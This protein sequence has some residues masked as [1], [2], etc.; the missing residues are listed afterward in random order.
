M[1]QA[2]LARKSAAVPVA[3]TQAPKAEPCGLRIG[4]PDDAFEQEADR[5]A[6]EVTAGGSSKMGWSLARVP[7]DARLQ[8]KCACGGAGEE[9]CEECKE[10]KEMTL[11][12][13]STGSGGLP[14]VPPI[15]HEV[16][17]SPGQS[18]DAA[19]KAFFEPRF[20]HDFSQVR[21]HSGG[22]AA[23][24][25]RS[26]G[27]LAYTAGNDIVF[28]TGQYNPFSTI[29]RGLLAHELTHV[30]QQRRAP[31]SGLV[32]QRKEW[33]VCKGVEVPVGR[34]PTVLCFGGLSGPVV[35]EAKR[36]LN[37]LHQQDT[38]WR[39][40][41]ENEKDDDS[42]ISAIQAFQRSR[43]LNRQDGALMQETMDA[44]EGSAPEA[45]T[46][47]AAGAAEFSL[48]QTQKHLD[49]L[50]SDLQYKQAFELLATLSDAQLR[51]VIAGAQ[52][53]DV[54]AGIIMALLAHFEIALTEKIDPGRL[55]VALEGVAWDKN[56]LYVDNFGRFYVDPK[57]FRR[58][59]ERERAGK[60]N[61]RIIFEYSLLTPDRAIARF[62]D[63]IE[64]SDAKSREAPRQGE[65]GLYYPPVLN[66]GN[67]P[68]MWQAKKDVIAKIEEGNF[69]FIMSAWLATDA[70][71]G[72]V[73]FGQ[74]MLAGTIPAA[75]GTA[76]AG[77]RGTS[78]KQEEKLPPGAGEPARPTQ[79]GVKATTPSGA[80]E[81]RQPPG[82]RTEQGTT[83]EPIKAAGAVKTLAYVNNNPKAS[84]GEI[85]VGTLLD[86]KAQAG[87]LK[88]FTRVE[89]AAEIS[90]QPSGDYRFTQPD[91]T[92][93][94]GDLYQ[95][96][97]KNVNNIF[98]AIL[99]KGRQGKIVVVELGE[100]ESGAITAD[101]ATEL[102]DSVVKQPDSGVRRV[103]VVK[104][105]TIVADKP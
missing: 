5:V 49:E 3:T 68:K 103:I 22:S 66:K 4:E 16:L 85:R 75:T 67:T 40:L 31:E 24:S 88:E 86:T 8:R 51:Q 64:D 50:V 34:A 74:S 104:G 76:A 59:E 61:I 62:A 54:G 33:A 44:L 26:L 37:A 100:G 10:K 89:G 83:R 84:A 41:P 13:Q 35:L 36:M 71:L 45:A 78:I 15:V 77:A 70:V 29:G 48:E 28:G 69:E 27:A 93:V 92:K 96:R 6:D 14:T 20:Y 18:L 72:M 53:E 90:G 12:R 95:P 94:P 87:G 23:E 7:I 47:P 21:I 9:E 25:A 91:G 1:R 79:G 56:K 98:D 81:T 63:D 52:K 97:I 43:R 73:G 2:V 17:Q 46:Q 101:Q 99:A 80:G 39:P 32:V 57:S 30:L 82:A 60:W 65:W 19:T 55:L 102:A 11:Q 38:N 105:D 58:N 42:T